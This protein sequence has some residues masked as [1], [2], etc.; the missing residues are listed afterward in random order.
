MHSFIPSAVDL[1]WQWGN[2]LQ[3]LWRFVGSLPY[4][5]ACFLMQVIWSLQIPLMETKISSST[6]EFKGIAYIAEL[7]ELHTGKYKCAST[8]QPSVLSYFYIYVPGEDNAQF[9]F[10][11]SNL[12][13]QLKL[14]YA[15]VTTSMINFLF[16]SKLVQRKFWKDVGN[17]FKRSASS[18]HRI[19]PSCISV[20]GQTSWGKLKLF[21]YGPNKKL[22]QA[23]I[24]CLVVSASIEES[25]SVWPSAWVFL[26]STRNSRSWRCIPMQ[27]RLQRGHQRAW[28]P[29]Q[30]PLRR[31][32][33]DES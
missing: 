19:Q 14:S 30:S 4:H 28:I 5:V 26:W 16:R 10:S 23:L 32:A 25:S 13:W 33:T 3:L 21:A 7:K 18:L 6:N 22:K 2:V 20:F 11:R 15:F 31:W 29:S 12:H 17:R 8:E 1:Q 9:W 27:S 24:K